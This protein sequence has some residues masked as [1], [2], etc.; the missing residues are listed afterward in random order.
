MCEM[1]KSLFLERPLSFLGLRTKV[2]SD[3]GMSTDRIL[4]RSFDVF[5]NHFKPQSTGT[6]LDIGVGTGTLSRLVRSYA[7]GFESHGVDYIS[8]HITDPELQLTVAD[9]NKSGLPYPDQ[10]FDFVSCVEVIEHLENFRAIVREAYRVLKPGGVVVFTTPNVLSLKSRIRYF[11]IGFPVLFGPIRVARDLVFSTNGH[12]TPVSYFF[13]SHVMTETG[14]ASLDLRVDKFQ[15]SAY[16]PFVLFYPLI[17]LFSL[18]PIYHELRK[19]KLN[20]GNK[21]LF[22]RTNS[23]NMLLGRTIVVSAVRPANISLINGH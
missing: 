7:P 12:I 18:I 23:V 16:L 13:L 22:N 10:S 17:K 6:H 15:R 11:L 4:D 14:F 19:L 1:Q 9:L 8:E 2:I 3:H 5:K 21:M 20:A